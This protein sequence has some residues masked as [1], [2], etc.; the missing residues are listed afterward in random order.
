MSSLCFSQERTLLVQCTSRKTFGAASRVVKAL[1]GLVR[2][3]VDKLWE[4]E[5]FRAG[6]EASMKFLLEHTERA[7]EAPALPLTPWKLQGR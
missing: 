4:H 5:G 7:D 1:P 2:R 6:N 3:R